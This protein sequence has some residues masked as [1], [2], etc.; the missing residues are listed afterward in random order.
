MELEN[1]EL[2]PMATMTQLS[3]K[4]MLRRLPRLVTNS[5]AV[6]EIH[7]ADI[8]DFDRQCYGIF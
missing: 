2:S 5:E 7:E 8:E 1:L 3:S 6:T 4:K